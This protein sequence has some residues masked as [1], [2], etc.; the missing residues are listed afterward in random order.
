MRPQHIN[1]ANEKLNAL[2]L[3]GIIPLP[4]L[5]FIN[6]QRL[7]VSMNSARTRINN[8][9]GINLEEII[10]S[11]FLTNEINANNVSELMEILNIEIQELVQLVYVNPEPQTLKLLAKKITLWG[12]KMG[13]SGVPRNGQT[14]H[15]LLSPTFNW[16]IYHKLILAI[17]TLDFN[18][19]SFES[20]NEYL[21]TI[22]RLGVS[23]FTKHLHFLTTNNDSLEQLPIY[24]KNIASKWFNK[25]T[26]LFNDYI[27]FYSWIKEQSAIYN[28][29][30]HDMERYMFNNA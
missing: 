7:I 1:F 15:F 25:N 13:L 30:I 18:L 27:D 14:N 21:K 10:P 19:E 24:D 16:N 26:V 12:G 17:R 8:T 29:P 4:N 20:I 11:A 2:L 9:E 22:P 3:N 23:F 6:D 5:P 28:I